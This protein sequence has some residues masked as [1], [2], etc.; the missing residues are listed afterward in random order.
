MIPV[1]TS[2]AVVGVLLLTVGASEFRMYQL[3][4]TSPHTWVPLEDRAP[5]LKFWEMMK[6]WCATLFVLA[7][8][9]TSY[10]IYTLPNA[11]LLP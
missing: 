6:S 8:M 7:M 4:E 9:A 5:K 11:A 2:M 10:F 1:F 3:R